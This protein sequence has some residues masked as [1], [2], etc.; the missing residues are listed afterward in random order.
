MSNEK[1]Q[2]THLIFSDSG[3]SIEILSAV[4]ADAH[5]PLETEIAVHTIR[6]LVSAIRAGFPKII[7]HKPALPQWIPRVLVWP[8]LLLLAYSVLVY[9]VAHDA[10][11][12]GYNI[13]LTVRAMKPSV[14]LR[15]T[16]PSDENASR[17]HSP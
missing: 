1:E 14:T 10:L 12:L 9:V 2:P 16:R 6:E 13:E 11:S 5:L 7:F 15:A 3:G 4:A 8:F 17:S